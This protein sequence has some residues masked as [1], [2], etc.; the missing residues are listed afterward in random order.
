MKIEKL[1]LGALDT[2]CYIFYDENISLEGKAICA[3]NQMD[4]ILQAP[5]FLKKFFEKNEE[6]KK[7]DQLYEI[8][9]IIFENLEKFKK[10]DLTST[11]LKFVYNNLKKLSFEQSQSKYY[12][13]MSY[14][15]TVVKSSCW[16][17]DEECVE[18]IAYFIKKYFDR[19]LSTYNH[20]NCYNEYYITCVP[21]VDFTQF[22]HPIPDDKSSQCI[23]RICWGKYVEQD[24][25]Y[26]LTLNI[27][28][29][30]IF[31]DGYPLAQTFNKIQELLN[32][33]DEI[34]K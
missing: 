7:S 9:W 14:I 24:G 6:I 13:L 11:A 22:T 3:I 8:C 17:I 23:P 10:Y 19:I 1:V 34:L 26:E 20:Q 27:T 32:N 33:V 28:V 29:S 31:V 5:N 30:H 16:D 2:N 12:E 4:R 15:L 25:K 18:F 21:W